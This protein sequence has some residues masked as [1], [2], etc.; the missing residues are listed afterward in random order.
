MFWGER[1]GRVASSDPQL[2]IWILLWPSIRRCFFAPLS[3]VDHGGE[4]DVAISEGL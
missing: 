3:R 1:S 2:H 4:D